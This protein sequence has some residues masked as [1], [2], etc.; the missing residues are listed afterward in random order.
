MTTDL[1]EESAQAASIGAPVV[2]LPAQT[3]T[4]NPDGTVPVGRGTSAS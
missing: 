4:Y 1:S 2:A 3:A